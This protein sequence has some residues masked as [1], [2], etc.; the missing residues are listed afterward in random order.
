[1]EYTQENTC[2]REEELSDFQKARVGTY[3]I[4][5]L[6]TTKKDLSEFTLN[7]CT[8]ELEQEGWSPYKWT[9]DDLYSHINSIFSYIPEAGRSRAANATSAIGIH[10][11]I[12]VGRVMSGLAGDSLEIQEE[13]EYY[14]LTED[15][16]CRSDENLYFRFRC[17]QIVMMHTGIGFLIIGIEGHSPLTPDLLLHA[18]Y[19]QNSS[20][21]GFVG[22]SNRTLGFV[23]LIERLLRGTGMTDYAG[24]LEQELPDSIL[25]DTSTYSVA[26][27]PKPF[28]RRSSKEMKELLKQLCLNLRHAR[29]FGSDNYEDE[30]EDS[31]FNCAALN[32]LSSEK[33][34]R[35]GIYTMFE[36]TAQVIFQTDGISVDPVNLNRDNRE[37]NYLPFLLIA[38]YERYSYLFFSEMLR[39]EERVTKGSGDWME[40]QMLRLKAF[41]VIL[42]TDMTPYNNENVFLAQQ[43]KIYAIDES[44]R[45]IDDKIGI[46]K[47]I[48]A[49]RVE[50]R[51]R[52]IEKILALFGVISILCDSLGLVDVLLTDT[53]SP[54]LYR[55][56]FGSELLLIAVA[57]LIS[58]ILYNRK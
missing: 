12:P 11:Q 3:F 13:Q 33:F 14:V 24:C 20:L 50:Q 54:H 22:I 57:A 45:L 16:R 51:R 4:I 56:T 35:W 26:V 5:P 30:D 15:S 21:L 37:D 55:V 28:C 32:S 47:H 41:G 19:N 23:D 25:R 7:E 34:I 27:L 40:E 52:L 48:Q 39:Y 9:F 42:P 6:R 36:R 10:Y 18:G 1:M 58:M 29:P 38:L 2:F 31:F 53:A 17:M 44:I 43:Q 8:R 46:I 49:D